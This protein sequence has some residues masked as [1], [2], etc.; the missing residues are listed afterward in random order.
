MTGK[1]AAGE[2]FPVQC[3][4]FPGVPDSIREVF[5]VE[6]AHFPARD[7]TVKGV[8]IFP[9]CLLSFPRAPDDAEFSTKYEETKKLLLKG[10][11]SYPA[12][13]NSE[14]ALKNMPGAL[15]GKKTDKDKSMI[16]EPF[17]MEVEAETDRR[18]LC[19]K[20]ISSLD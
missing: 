5:Q 12:L 17:A 7:I 9:G 10:R 13:F 11:I 6:C 3:K 20:I 2:H 16:K 14:I 18:I 1:V 19:E 15:Q 4:F 8:G